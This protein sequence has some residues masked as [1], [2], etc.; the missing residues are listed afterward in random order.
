M[1]VLLSLCSPAVYKDTATP[2]PFVERFANDDGCGARSALPDH[3]Y[4]DCMG[5]G[6][7]C[8]CLQVTFQACDI[9]EARHLYDQL[10]V[11]C[12]VMVSGNSR[13]CVFV[14]FIGVILFSSMTSLPFLCVPLFVHVCV[15]LFMC[16]AVLYHM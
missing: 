4:M 7:G 3:I 11:V 15:Y 14:V 1:M 8:S 13:L 10:A 5:F 6:M 9:E 2:S 12:P 16:V